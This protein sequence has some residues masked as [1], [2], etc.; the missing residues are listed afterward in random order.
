[1][2]TRSIRLSDLWPLLV[3]PTLSAVFFAAVVL[4]TTR[5]WGL[6]VISGV[7]VFFGSFFVLA[8]VYL[9]VGVARAPDERSDNSAALL[10]VMDS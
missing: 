7:L 10:K 4:M 9:A 2:R 3:L 6:S 8:I 1:M 5:A